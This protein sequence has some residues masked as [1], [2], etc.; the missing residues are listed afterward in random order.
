MGWCLLHR[1]L[2]RG[3]RHRFSLHESREEHVADHFVI[4]LLDDVQLSPSLF[5]FLLMLLFAR[6]N[7]VWEVNDFVLGSVFRGSFLAAWLLMVP[8]AWSA[9][10]V[11][12]L[13]HFADIE[14][15]LKEVVVLHVLEVPLR[16]T[17]VI[18][19]RPL[20]VEEFLAF[21]HV[22]WSVNGLLLVDWASFGGEQGLEIVFVAHRK[23]DPLVQHISQL[24]LLFAKLNNVHFFAL[25]HRISQFLILLNF[26]NNSY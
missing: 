7:Q 23:V 4:Y 3:F 15:P 22:G 24:L 5:F 25:L 9:V 26:L 14:V 20:L 13:H 8:F 1:R 16:L 11:V 19:L 6:E 18:V 12:L 21:V 17:F 10:R 2:F